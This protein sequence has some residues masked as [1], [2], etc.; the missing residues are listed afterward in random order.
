MELYWAM[1]LTWVRLI[2]GVVASVNGPLFGHILRFP[3]LSILVPMVCSEYRL[4]FWTRGFGYFT[5]RLL[6]YQSTW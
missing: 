4:Y 1:S 6:L 3:F 2:S 5:M